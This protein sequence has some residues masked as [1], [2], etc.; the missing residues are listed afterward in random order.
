MH[1]IRSVTG[2]N[3]VMP[4]EIKQLQA[5]FHNRSMDGYAFHQQAFHTDVK[6]KDWVLKPDFWN[7]SLPA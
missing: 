5:A 2:K 6:V 4:E 3:A 1:L 7:Y